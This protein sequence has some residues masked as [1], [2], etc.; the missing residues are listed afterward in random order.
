MNDSEKR[1]AIY[2]APVAGSPWWNALSTWL[3]YDAASGTLLMQASAPPLEDRLLRELTTH[4]RRYGAH[5]TLK[6]PFRLAPQYCEDELL[7]AVER[8]TS[9]CSAFPMPPLSIG[10]INSFIGLTMTH[11]EARVNAIAEACTV[12]FDHFRAPPTVHEMAHRLRE[13][14]DSEQRALLALWGYPHVLERYCFHISLT[15]DLSAFSD[16]IKGAA[17]QAV[18]NRFDTLLKLSMSFDAVCVFCQASPSAN[19]R[20]IQRYALAS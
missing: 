14:L 16:D 20:L 11:P 3:G 5:A 17:L 6:A 1:Y 18:K 19:F 9:R 10:R 13:P 8:F 7:A 2:F 4:P 12:E 15:G